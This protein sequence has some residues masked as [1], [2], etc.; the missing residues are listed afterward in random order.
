MRAV[1]ICL[2]GMLLV[3][4]TGFAFGAEDTPA[5]PEADLGQQKVTAQKLLDEQ[6]YLV[7]ESNTATHTDTSLFDLPLSLQVVPEQVMQDQAA[8]DVYEALRNV[9]GVHQN[10]GIAYNSTD[11]GGIIRGFQNTQMYYN[12]FLIEASSAFNV[13]NLSRVEVLKGPSSMLYGVVQPGGIINVVTKTPQ[14]TQDAYIQQWFGSYDSYRSTLD[15]TGPI[16]DDGTLLYRLNGG[17]YN[18]GSFRDY[19]EEER[20]WAAPSLTFRPTDQTTITVDMSY[21]ERKRTLDEGVSFGPNGK[22]VGS[23][24]RF[25]GE[26][27]LPGQQ[28]EDFFVGARLEHEISDAL[29]LR[30]GMLYHH[31]KINLDG[32]RRSST[33]ISPTGDVN[34]LYDNSDFTE[35][36]FQWN[37]ELLWKFDLGPTKHQLLTG[38]DV[39][40]RNQAIDLERAGYTTVNIYNP[41]YGDPFPATPLLLRLEFDRTWAGVYM[42][43][44]ISMLEDDRLKLLLGGRY[45][46]VETTDVNTA[47]TPKETDRSDSVFTGRA[48]LLYELTD[49]M[50]AYGSVSQSFVPSSTSSRTVSGDLLDPEEGLQYETGLKFRFF[51]DRVLTTV[52]VYELTKDNVAVADPTNPSFSINGG[53]QR[54]R[55]VEFDFSGD[56]GGGWSVIGN[57]TYTDTEVLSSD[58]LPVGGRFPNVPLHSGSIWMRY[59]LLNGDFKG[60]GFGAGVFTASERSGDNNSSFQIGGYERVDLGIF[61]DGQLPTGQPFHAQLNVKNVF[62][63]EYYESSFGLTRVFPG[64]PLTVVFTVGMHF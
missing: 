5:T 1:S 35:D 23:I 43:D 50:G 2:A 40:H 26:P 14:P 29:T 28:Q 36:S 3:A 7:D 62:D 13:P 55:G 49:S 34:R 46:W 39:R 15:V 16:S 58:S 22:P 12:G 17:Y 56:L 38:V 31:W 60:L 18:E 19:V 32:V 8:K 11:D 30:T 48:G 44:Q 41:Q 53:E 54:S 57:Y 51:E 63:T 6:T 61:Y 59:T 45:D 10:R 42:Q 47:G 21:G 33:T 52:A 27:G 37:G 4:V 24:E 9:S 20:F 25:L 64:D